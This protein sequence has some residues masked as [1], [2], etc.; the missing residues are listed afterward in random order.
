MPQGSIKSDDRKISPPSRVD[1]KNSMEALIHHFKLY[2]EGYYVPK[3]E[4]YSGV[5]HPKGEFGVSII[6]DGSKQTLPM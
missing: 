2:S 1:M 6:S 3:G 4:A 5:E